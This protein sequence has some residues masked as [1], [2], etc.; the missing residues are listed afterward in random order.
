MPPDAEYWAAEY[1]AQRYDDGLHPRGGGP[2]LA[3]VEHGRTAHQQPAE[4]VRNLTARRQPATGECPHPPAR[5]FTW[6]AYDGT[7]CAACCDCGAVLA[8]A[9]D[10]EDVQR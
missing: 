4:A 6:W 5:I 9:A 7:L 2:S 3:E 8:G 10:A 1:D